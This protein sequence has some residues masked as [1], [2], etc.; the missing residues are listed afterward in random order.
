MDE[1]P[2]DTEMKYLAQG[3]DFAMHRVKAGFNS[4]WPRA[5]TPPCDGAALNFCIGLTCNSFFVVI[6]VIVVILIE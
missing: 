4:G 6:I 3:G 5:P 1:K 2:E